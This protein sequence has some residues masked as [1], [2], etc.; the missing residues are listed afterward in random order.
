MEKIVDW[1]YLKRFKLVKLTEML[2]EP[3]LMYG[4]EIWHPYSEGR[5][6]VDVLDR[7]K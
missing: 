2:I 1:R 6:M 3:I 4:C 7:D 5:I